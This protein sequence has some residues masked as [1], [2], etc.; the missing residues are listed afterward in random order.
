MDRFWE[1]FH[2]AAPHQTVTSA[3]H[4]SIMDC[5]QSLGITFKEEVPILEGLHTVDVVISLP[6]GGRA[7]LE[8]DGP[9]HYLRTSLFGGSIIPPING[10]TRMRNRIITSPA[11]NFAASF[12]VPYY[13]WELLEGAGAEREYITNL[14]A[15]QGFSL[16]AMKFVEPP[17]SST[18]I[19]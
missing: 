12:T 18:T 7:A 10:T 4:V 15:A 13:E 6:G 8:V 3:L 19:A 5:L 1:I 17:P 14:F 2:A 9:T 16:E 11:A